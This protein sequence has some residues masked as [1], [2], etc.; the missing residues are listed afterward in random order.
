MGWNRLQSISNVADGT[1][2]VSATLGSNVSSYSKIIVAVAFYSGVTGSSTSSVSDGAGNNWTKLGGVQTGDNNGELSLWALDVPAGDIGNRPTLTAT[3]SVNNANCAIAIYVEEDS[4]LLAGNTTGMLDGALAVLNGTTYGGNTGSPSYAS[5]LVGEYLVAVYGDDSGGAA[6]TGPAGWTVDPNSLNTNS[7]ENIALAYKDSTGG[8]ETDGF[9][10]SSGSGGWAVLMGAF[11]LAAF[12]PDPTV[13]PGWIRTAPAWFPGSDV[14][15]TAP[16]GTPFYSQPLPSYARPI[17]FTVVSRQEPPAT[18]PGWFPGADSAAANPGGIPFYT[19][20]TPEYNPSIPFIQWRVG[21]S[22]STTTMTIPSSVQQGDVILIAVAEWEASPVAL[23]ATVSSSG[24]TQPQLSAYT[25]YWDAYSGSTADLA[26]LWTM[27]AAAGDAGATLTLSGVTSYSTWCLGAWVGSAGIDVIAGSHTVSGSEVQTWSTGPSTVS[28]Q[29]SDWSISIATDFN[30]GSLSTYPGTLRQEAP[31]PAGSGT[32]FTIGITDSNGPIGPAGT[33]LVSGSWANTSGTSPWAG[34]VIGL[35]PLGVNLTPGTVGGFVSRHRTTV[36]ATVKTSTVAGGQSGTANSVASGI[37]GSGLQ[38]PPIQR[39][40]STRLLFRGLSVSPQL[41]VLAIPP[42]ILPRQKA[43]RGFWRNG[44]V[45]TANQSYLN[46]T[47][48][49]VWRRAA[50]RGLWR[51]SA[52][53][54]TIN[55]SYFSSTNGVVSRRPKIARAFWRSGAILAGNKTYY[56]VTSGF[57]TRR[58]PTRVYVRAGA[59][60]TVNLSYLNTTGS[61]LVRR[62]VVTRGQ[63][64]SNVL[65]QTTNLRYVNVTNGVVTRRSKLARAVWRSGAVPTSNS[66][67]LSINSGLVRRRQAVRSFWRTGVVVQTS[68]LLYL[69]TTNGLIRR[70]AATRGYWR[71]GAVP[72]VNIIQSVSGMAPPKLILKPRVTT[73][74]YWRSGAVLTANKSY[75]NITSGLVRRRLSARAVWRSGAVAT[76]NL[77]STISSVVPPKL[78]LRPRTTARASWRSGAVPTV[79]QSYLNS[80]SGLVRRRATARAIWRSGAISTVNQVSTIAGTVP[81]K[82]ILRP[83]MSSRAIGHGNIV[84]TSNKTYTS[85][86]QGLVRRRSVARVSWLG[87]VVRTTNQPYN[88]TTGGLVKRR[89]SARASWFGTIVRT[90]NTTFTAATGGLVR[91]RPSLRGYWAGIVVRTVNHLAGPAG[92]APGGIVVRRAHPRG[93]W[94]S[95]EVSTVNNVIVLVPLPELGVLPEV[96]LRLDVRLARIGLLDSSVTVLNRID[97]W[98]S[99]VEDLNV[100]V[101]VVNRINVQ[102]ETE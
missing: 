44:A 87:A 48:G 15:A 56:S 11:Q 69:N 31:A 85:S 51:T 47:G 16:D 13:Y 53:V 36:R 40:Q 94:R 12:A 93:S 25:Q 59:V 67:Y 99:V 57:I 6:W 63:W 70:R 7:A 102:A 79:N 98:K 76:T 91:R 4:G 77:V 3:G 21:N 75:L 100:Q 1:N 45:A 20:P 38:R 5:S 41:P 81:P 2:V 83:R 58:K 55:R 37:S 8:T 43:T 39:R 71:S 97:V 96:L 60:P 65:V 62:G 42:P 52:L 14:V 72:T 32:G 17:P 68:N 29:G 92:N 28:R 101:L 10:L 35:A 64:R 89:V 22:S 73:R 33:N 46:V 61:G 9:S 80:T 27:T 86:T 24:P 18:P 95:T 82:L 78:I 54:Q 90:V 34:W 19:V 50:A 26:Q 66:S 23:T 49:L 30:G 74:A 84:P 88:S